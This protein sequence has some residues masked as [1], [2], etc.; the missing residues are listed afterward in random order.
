MQRAYTM[1]SL[2]AYFAIYELAISRGKK[3]GESMQ[4]EFDE[5]LEQHPEWFELLGDIDQDVDQITGNLR[6]KGFNVVNP[7]EIDRRK[8]QENNN[9]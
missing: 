8:E 4:K 6:E 3:P 1:K 5:I 9:A 7:H 2:D